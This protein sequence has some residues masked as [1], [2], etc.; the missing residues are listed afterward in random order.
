MDQNGMVEIL[1]PRVVRTF[2]SL[3][4][5]MSRSAP[6]AWTI[7][8]QVRPNLLESLT[9]TGA[10]G[11][12]QRGVDVAEVDAQS[13]ALFPVDVEEELRARRGVGVR[14]RVRHLLALAHP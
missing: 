9:W 2:S 4:V 11:D 10:E 13:L 14:P 3:I 12:L 5:S 6:G 7:T 1:S 8:C